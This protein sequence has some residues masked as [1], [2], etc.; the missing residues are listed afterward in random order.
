MTAN[1][2]K[3][4]LGELEGSSLS[5]TYGD[6]LS[7]YKVPSQVSNE[8]KMFAVVEYDKTPIRLGL[9]CDEL[10][11]SSLR[12]A[13]ESVMPSDRLNK[14]YWITILLTGQVPDDWIS[15]LI[16]LSYNLAKSASL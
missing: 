5:F 6:D 15:G 1:E 16:T 3:N 14:K 8:D 13:Y 9:R 12:E 2:L 7:V 11:A 4:I 10:L